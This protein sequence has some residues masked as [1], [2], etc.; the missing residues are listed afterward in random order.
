MVAPPLV[1][2]VYQLTTVGT[3]NGMACDHVT[4]WHMPGLAASSAAVAKSFADSD[5]L[6]WMPQMGSNLPTY[7]THLNSSGVYLGAGAAPA[8]QTIAGTP[9]RATGPFGSHATCVTIRHHVPVKGRGRQGRTNIP[10]PAVDSIA[11][12]SGQL[13]PAAQTAYSTAFATYRNAIQGNMLSLYG[14]SPELVILSRK[15]G[16]FLV[17]TSS[18][19]DVLPNTH[20]RW[21]KRLA[22][23]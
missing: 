16:I 2:D 19:C 22:R 3:L 10:G 1:T 20:R 7:Y 23:H 18:E 5:V 9:G 6:A 14:V 8:G 4:H 21:Q 12:P 17:P 13:T 11:E 15:T